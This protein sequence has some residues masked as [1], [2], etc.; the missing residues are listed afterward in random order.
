LYGFVRII[1]SKGDL[2]K[3]GLGLFSLMLVLILSIVF[4]APWDVLRAPTDWI[5][6]IEP[7]I[8]WVLLLVSASVFLIALLALRKKY[9]VKLVFVAGAFGLFGLKSLLVVIDL[10]ASMGNFMNYSILAFFDLLTIG[11]LFLALFKK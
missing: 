9:S 5:N 7:I 1:L 10:Y 2:M 8:V 3:Y 11:C 6:V 4:A